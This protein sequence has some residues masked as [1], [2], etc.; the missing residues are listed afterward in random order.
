MLAR[1]I[2]ALKRKP[3]HSSTVNVQHAGTRRGKSLGMSD[4]VQLSGGGMLKVGIVS[5]S[6]SIGVEAGDKDTKID[7]VA[8]IVV[9]GN[10]HLVAGGARNRTTGAGMTTNQKDSIENARDSAH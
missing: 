2:R 5:T 4:L 3:R 6:S 8:C 1:W 10:S 9:V 7:N